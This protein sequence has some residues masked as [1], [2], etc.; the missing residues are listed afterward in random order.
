MVGR[1]SVETSRTLFYSYSLSKN[2]S[3]QL[4]QHWKI[5]NQDILLVIMYLFLL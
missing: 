4:K 1:D 2:R 3:A 5:I